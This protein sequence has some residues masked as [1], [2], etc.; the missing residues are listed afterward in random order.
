VRM[1]D[2][3]RSKALAMTS[4]RA[5]SHAAPSPA[6]PSTR[7]LAGLILVVTVAVLYVHWPALSARAILFDDQQYVTE[8]HLVQHP[9]WN[10]T[11][12]F[13]GRFSRPPR[14]RATINP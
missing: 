13:L 11:R 10:S 14:S 8:N 1:R 9:S 2:K 12:R 3:R 5:E 6:N 7:V 4:K